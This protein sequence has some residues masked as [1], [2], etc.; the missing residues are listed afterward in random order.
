M[1]RQWP[2]FC[3]CKTVLIIH[4][5][6]LRNSGST[7]N[8][9]LIQVYCTAT[10]RTASR[11]ATTHPSSQLFKICPVPLS[12][13]TLLSQQSEE[14]FM[15]QIR[16]GFFPQEGQV[17]QEVPLDSNHPVWWSCDRLGSS[18]KTVFLLNGSRLGKESQGTEKLF[19]LLGEK[20]LPQDSDKGTEAQKS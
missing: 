6:T 3:V 10:I 8:Y 13:S 16:S 14:S 11:K 1:S 2:G 7:K 15:L 12:L 5:C 17:S 19:E 20:Q 9:L 4:K 18:S